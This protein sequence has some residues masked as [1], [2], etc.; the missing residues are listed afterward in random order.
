MPSKRS[1]KTITRVALRRHIC[2]S[3]GDFFFALGLMKH[4][5]F[6][7]LGIYHNVEDFVTQ[8]QI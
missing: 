4:R 6:R 3:V 2:V 5:E 7:Q 8:H 1:E